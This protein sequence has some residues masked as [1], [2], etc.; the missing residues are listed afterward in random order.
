MCLITVLSTEEVLR[1]ICGKIDVM[2]R[3]NTRCVNITDSYLKECA[4]GELLLRK[5]ASLATTVKKRQRP[6]MKEMYLQVSIIIWQ[7]FPIGL[8]H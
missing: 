3:H 7:H 5:Q 2:L 8:R 6:A 4:A 1:P